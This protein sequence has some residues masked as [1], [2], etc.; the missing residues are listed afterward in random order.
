MM[1]ELYLYLLCSFFCGWAFYIDTSHDVPLWQ[2]V[3]AA[4]TVPFWAPI[5]ILVVLISIC[6]SWV[7]WPFYFYN[8][9][10]FYTFTYKFLGVTIK[11][12]KYGLF[13]KLGLSDKKT[14]MGKGSGIGL[15]INKKTKCLLAAINFTLK[16]ED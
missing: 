5:V 16:S 1:F 13:Y 15:I 11:N 10:D 9:T 12:K 7:N 14:T 8:K 6:F 3:L 4:I 2:I